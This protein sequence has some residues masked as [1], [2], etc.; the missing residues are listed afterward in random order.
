VSG[1]IRGPAA[2]GPKGGGESQ[3]KLRKAA[4][5]LE[6]IFVSEL[7]KAMRATVPQDGLLGQAPGQDMFQGM[8]DERV[9]EVY[10]ERSTHGLGEALYHQLSRRLPEGK[11]SQE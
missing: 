3:A 10:A 4:H 5:D 7:F 9:A 6:G 1:P 11:R 8:M 2:P